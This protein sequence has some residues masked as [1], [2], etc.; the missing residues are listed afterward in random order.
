MEMDWEDTEEDIA[1]ESSKKREGEESEG[2][3]RTLEATGLGGLVWLERWPQL[4]K[5][6]ENDTAHMR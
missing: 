1:G 3:G 5:K 6:L 2:L 4:I